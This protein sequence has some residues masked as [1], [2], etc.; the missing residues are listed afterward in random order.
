[1][2]RRCNARCR[3]CYQ[4]NNDG[5][6]YQDVPTQRWLDFFDELSRAK[7]LQV[8]LAGGEPLLRN[9][10]L[11]LIQGIAARRMRWVLLT[12]GCP[13]TPE[14]AQRFQQIGRCASV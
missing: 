12:N 6:V 13:V 8:S 1:L 10:V 11:E 9:D 14:V 3:Y 2:T 5:V 7:V 4:Q